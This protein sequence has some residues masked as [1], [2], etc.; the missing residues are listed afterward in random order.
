MQK[1]P[2]N[3]KNIKTKKSLNLNKSLSTSLKA[4]RE[5]LCVPGQKQI[6]LWINNNTLLAGNNPS[7]RPEAGDRAGDLEGEQAE[8]FGGTGGTWEAPEGK[9]CRAG[10][11]R[12]PA[13]DHQG[14]A[15]QRARAPPD[16][17]EHQA[18]KGPG[19]KDQTGGQ[20]RDQAE[21]HEC[22]A[23]ADRGAGDQ[24]THKREHTKRDE[25]ETKKA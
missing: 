19:D 13:A 9:T 3:S 11:G 25:K 21:A 16:A 23:E 10:K 18:S 20:A 17:R 22:Q 24:T 7:R 6:T 1:C 4:K 2:Q 14:A 15:S 5:P 8:A 12:D